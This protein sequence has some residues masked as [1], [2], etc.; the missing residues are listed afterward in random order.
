MSRYSIIPSWD[1]LFSQTFLSLSWI[2]VEGVQQSALRVWVNS[3]RLFLTWRAKDIPLCYA[4]L[5]SMLC[6][7]SRFGLVL[8]GLGQN[9]NPRSVLFPVSQHKFVWHKIWFLPL[10]KNMELFHFGR[11]ETHD[12]D[13]HS[14][15][16]FLWCWNYRCLLLI[17]RTLGVFKNQQN[18]S[19]NIYSSIV[20]I[21]L[22]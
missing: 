20:C 12:D 22:N 16:S 17:K 19:R 6:M 8:N 18:A 11:I 3:P 2:P 5:R 21:Y 14:A 9:N 4:V 13:E 7:G 1:F 15:I 10:M